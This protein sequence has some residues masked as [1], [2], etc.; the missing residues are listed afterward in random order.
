M[1]EK[2][3]RLATVPCSTGDIALD[4][5]ESDSWDEPMV[6]IHQPRFQGAPYMASIP[7]EVVLKAADAIRRHRYRAKA[8]P[9]DDLHR[10][11]SID[12]VR[13]WVRKHPRSGL[14]MAWE[15]MLE[16]IDAY[17]D[18]YSLDDFLEEAAIQEGKGNV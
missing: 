18:E 16:D 8:M 11:T 9:S 1:D 14:A 6:L 5:D 12:E 2:V 15:Q 13:T 4:L 17:G 10:L 7:A 3:V